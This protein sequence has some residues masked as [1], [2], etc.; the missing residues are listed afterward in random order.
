MNLTYRLICIAI[1][2]ITTYIIRVLPMS[3]F[4]KQLKSVFIQSFLY[5]V[6]YAV[7][8]ALTFPSVFYATGNIYSSII[9]TIIAIILAFFNRGLV[10]VAVGAIASALII[11][12]L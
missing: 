6:P 3:I 2:S 7:L 5:Y 1:M 10:I 9:G 12:F 4:K 8:A 11:N